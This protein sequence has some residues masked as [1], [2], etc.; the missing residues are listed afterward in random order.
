MF[1]TRAT[2]SDPAS[3]TARRQARLAALA[4]SALALMLV[5]V[6]TFSPTW[7]ALE[8]KTFDVLTG[9]TAPRRTDL[10][11]VVLA[12]DEPTFQEL[13]QAWPFPR[14]LHAAL[15]RRLHDEG[16]AAVG[17]DIVFADPSTEAEDAALAQAIAQA[18][19]VVLAATREKIDSGDRK[20][21]R[22]NSSHEFVSRMPS[23]A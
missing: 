19:P 4:A 1:W 17:M 2:A 21:T 13:Q 8:F 23:S 18:A 20:S 5:G 14:S 15:L 16:A 10:P 7:H 22:L 12:I 3:P 11:V 6:A 9:L